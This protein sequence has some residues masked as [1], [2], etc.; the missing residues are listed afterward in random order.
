M[1][2]LDAASASELFSA[3]ESRGQGGNPPNLP[4]L[5]VIEAKPSISKGLDLAPPHQ[6]L[7]VIKAKHS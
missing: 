6:I 4:I 2:T 3:V 1:T 5:I 7:A